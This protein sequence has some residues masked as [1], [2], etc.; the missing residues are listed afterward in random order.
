MYCVRMYVITLAKNTLFLALFRR[1]YALC[2]LFWYIYTFTP[3][4][5]LKH[6]NFALF[7]GVYILN[8]QKY[9]ILICAEQ[10]TSVTT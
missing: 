3:K 6:A 2:T 10:A 4:N 1:L 8:L 5:T 7:E 9:N